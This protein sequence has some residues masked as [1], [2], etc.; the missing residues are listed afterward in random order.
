MPSINLGR[1]GGSGGDWAQNDPNSADTIKTMNPYIS[2][3]T[4]DSL[5]AGKVLYDAAMA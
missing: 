5:H 2:G 3:V 4:S 1:V